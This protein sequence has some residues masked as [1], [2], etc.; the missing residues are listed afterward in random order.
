MPCDVCGGF[1]YLRDW[2]YPH[3]GKEE[4]ETGRTGIAIRNGSR[5]VQRRAYGDAVFARVPVN[6]TPLRENFPRGFEL[7][8]AYLNKPFAQLGALDLYPPSAW[9][10]AYHLKRKDG[11]RSPDSALEFNGSVRRGRRGRWAGA[12]AGYGSNPGWRPRLGIKPGTIPDT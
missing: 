9:N 8:P 2:A 11:E 6:G 7:A 4:L 10:F 12:Y 3:S 1:G 5:C